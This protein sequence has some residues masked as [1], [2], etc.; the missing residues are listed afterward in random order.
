MKKTLVLLLSF[1]LPFCFGCSPQNKLETTVVTGIVKVNGKPME[2]VTVIFNPTASDANPAV[3]STNR[4]GAFRL[5]TPGGAAGGGAIPGGYIPTFAKDEVEKLEAASQEEYA[6]K[7]GNRQPKMIHHLPTKYADP[8]T[9]GFLP[10]TIEKGKKNHFEF[11]LTSK[12]M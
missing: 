1:I 3:G 7:Y 6:K 8:K 9:C 4:S 5:S 11:D 2:D 12:A 10:I